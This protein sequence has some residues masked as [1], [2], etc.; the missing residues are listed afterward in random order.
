MTALFLSFPQ[1]MA[2]FSVWVILRQKSNKNSRY[3]HAVCSVRW[4]SLHHIGESTNIKYCKSTS[5]LCAIEVV[6]VA[7]QRPFHLHSCGTS[8]ENGKYTWTKLNWIISLLEETFSNF[9]CATLLVNTE[10]VKTYL[11]FHKLT[12]NEYYH[13]S[14]MT[15]VWFTAKLLA[16][17]GAYPAKSWNI[18]SQR[19]RYT[20]FDQHNGVIILGKRQLSSLEKLS[21]Y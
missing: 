21:V 9:L 1:Y 14:M 20:Q 11:L 18:I 16:Q 13:P 7:E 2:Y 3:F 6:L 4:S 8:L 12:R 15:S 19:E 5:Y 17:L 10:N